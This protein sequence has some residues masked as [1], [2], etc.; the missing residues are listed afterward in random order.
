MCRV[1]GCVGVGVMSVGVL[2]CECPYLEGWK[3]VYVFELMCT[4]IFTWVWLCGG[5]DGCVGVWVCY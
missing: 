4:V 2:L 5:V 1:A 3:V